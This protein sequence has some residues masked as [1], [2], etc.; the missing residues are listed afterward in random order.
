LIGWQIITRDIESLSTATVDE[1]MGH[2]T[3]LYQLL[4]LKEWSGVI[5]A[6]EE[7]GYASF[8]QTTHPYV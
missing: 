2:A 8:I 4:S 6:F 3:G 5:C 7:E 1:G